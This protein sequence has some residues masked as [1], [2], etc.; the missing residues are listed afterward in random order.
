[1]DIGSVID[2]ASPFIP[3]DLAGEG[4]LTVGSALT[5]I[6][7]HA[8][9]VIAIG[10]F[11][12]MPNRIAEAILNNTMNRSGKMG[13]DPKNRDLQS[14]LATVDHLPFLAIESD[15]RPFSQII[16]AKL[17]AFLIGAKRLHIKMLNHSKINRDKAPP[18]AYSA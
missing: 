7:S 15:G 16:E 11:G 9:G 6:A 12:C 3:L 5:N 18:I 10:P 4:I 13:T 1:V 2:A 8:C 17:E 14:L